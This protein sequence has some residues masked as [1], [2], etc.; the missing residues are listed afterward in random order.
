MKLVLGPKIGSKNCRYSQKDGIF[1]AD[2]SGI[3]CTCC[4]AVSLPRPKLDF[5]IT[6]TKTART[7]LHNFRGSAER[8]ARSRTTMP[9]SCNDD[10]DRQELVGPIV[11]N[12]L[13]QI[14]A[15]SAKKCGITQPVL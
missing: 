15:S 12:G 1:D 10:V 2:I 11:D 9:V 7:S 8:A 6:K 4:S 3:E 14:S 5:L 13:S